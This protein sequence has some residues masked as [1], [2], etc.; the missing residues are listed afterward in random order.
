MKVAMRD[1][2]CS[3]VTDLQPISK[4]PS[5][6]RYSHY[7]V[8]WTTIFFLPQI[9]LAL[10]VQIGTPYLE[11]VGGTYS[12]CPSVFEKKKSSMS[13]YIIFLVEVPS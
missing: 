8:I 6:S 5:L 11:A 2:I 3:K 12:W 7:E 4:F 13:Q 1:F 10:S 9:W